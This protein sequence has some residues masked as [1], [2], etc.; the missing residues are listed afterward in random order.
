MSEGI[1]TSRRQRNLSSRTRR[2][3]LLL[4]LGMAVFTVPTQTG[5]GGDAAGPSCANPGQSCLE[6]PCCPLPD[7]RVSMTQTFSY[8]GGVQTVSACTCGS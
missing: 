7:G 6:Q 8:P 3:A 1:V 5:C 2:V 4:V